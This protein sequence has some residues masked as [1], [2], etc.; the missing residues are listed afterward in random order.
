MSNARASSLGENNPVISGDI[1]SAFSNPAS[2]GN[3]ESMPLSFTNKY[4]LEEFQHQLMNIGVPLDIR[5]P[6]KGKA[7]PIQRVM[8]GFNY[9]SVTLSEIPQTVL[10]NG[11]P[12][13]IGSFS[14]GFRVY[15]A[16]AS[17]L[18]YNF[19]GLNALSIGVQ[20]KLTE[21]FSLDKSS[22]AYSVDIGGIGTRFLPYKY[23]N[24]ISLGMTVQNI[25]STSF[26]DTSSN[27]TLLPFD[28]LAGIRLNAFDGRALFYGHNGING[29]TLSTEYFLQ[30]E[31]SLRGSTDLKRISVG[32]GLLFE[33]IATGFGN[34][35]YSIRLDYNYTHHM[36]PLT[37]TNHSF[38]VSVLG[39][40]RAKA[41]RILM[42]SNDFQ[43]TSQ[44]TIDLSGV[45]PK[46]TTI[47]LFNNDS[48]SRSVVTNK[49][50]QWNISNFPLKE[51]KN[52]IYL[53][54]YT[55]NKASSLQSFPI[56][57]VSDTLPPQLQTKIYPEGENL[58]ITLFSNENLSALSGIIE[59]K[60]IRFKKVYA[61]IP[62]DMDYLQKKETLPHDLPTEWIARLPL[63]KS[64][65]SSTMPNELTNLRFSAQDEAGNILEK[66]DV[67]F[68][69]SIEFP[70]DKYVHYKDTIRFIGLSSEVVNAVKI[71]DNPVYIDP[72]RRFSI[73]ILLKKG[74]NN[75]RIDI[76]TTSEATLTYFM[77]ILYLKTYPDLNNR[78]RGR[79]EIEFLSTV[80]ILTGDDDGNF[81]PFKPVTR[82]Y[83]AK[84]M[85]LASGASTDIL[86]EVTDSLY[87]DVPKEHPFA[88]YIQAA[89]EAGLIF[90][91]PDGSFKPEQS[92]SLSEAVFLLSN[93]GVIA[94]QDIDSENSG[95]ISRNQLAEF[96]AYSPEF[97]LRIEDLI[98]WDSGY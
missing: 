26:S 27:K 41:P 69:S 29:I 37:E 57:V 80:G 4:V 52:L 95:P 65:L 19:F 46:N 60:E 53:Q 62:D 74:K 33:N 45:G 6:A 23:V 28:I 71:N 11:I 31:I 9:G 50:G 7:P 34:N 64:L 14:S 63:P 66:D 81:Y 75:V 30:D 85:L 3:I 78:V 49:F 54:S 5:L 89:V 18:F 47:Q 93:A 88:E 12:M 91:F 48:L 36:P 42:P 15:S 97:E 20:P 21:L 58:I 1:G 90:A 76:T 72:S 32:S 8:L 55:L 61:D 25:L 68:F 84:L 83:I 40:S 17:T 79:R 38:S 16:G 98:N 92:L 70:K 24:D 2:I 10:S 39:E 94:Y 86:P 67:T 96:L 51:G 82:Q 43:I 59:N 87:T 44:R 77:R 56:I 73:P 22:R 13:Q 35:S